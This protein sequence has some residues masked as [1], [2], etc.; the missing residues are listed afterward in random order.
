MGKREKQEDTIFPDKDSISSKNRL[1][2]VCDGMGG[3]AK[4]EVA[5]ATVCN[6]V[7][8]WINSHM[9]EDGTLTD[10][11]LR[12]AINKAR[13][14]LDKYDDGSLKKMGTTLTL[15]SIHNGGVTM[16][17]I[18]DSR[19]YHIRPKEHRILYKTIDHSLVYDM[20][21][22]GEISYEE[23]ATSARRNVITRALMP[24]EDNEVDIDITHTTDVLPG[25]YFFL[26]TDGMLEQTN[27]KQL[28]DILCAEG[29]DEKKESL[30]KSTTLDNK[31]NH[32]AILV[33]IKE[34]AAELND[35]NLLND[36]ATSPFN[37]VALLARMAQT[38]KNESIQM[39][40]FNSSSSSH[41]IN[42][43]DPHQVNVTLE[44][45]ETMHN[46]NVNPLHK[47]II[48]ILLALAAVGVLLY[49]FLSRGNDNKEEPPTRI[50][51]NVE[52]TPQEEIN[53][54]FAPDNTRET[55]RH[56]N[57][58]SS[59]SRTQTT[60]E[61]SAT[62]KPQTTKASK[63]TPAETKKDP[64]GKVVSALEEKEEQEKSASENAAKEDPKQNKKQIRIKPKTPQTDPQPQPK[65]EPETITI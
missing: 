29:S 39:D 58:A 59:S 48:P 50:E 12:E 8:Q 10:S 63:N 6:A 31:D 21:Q 18:G 51:S 38:A 44:Y 30:L 36:E 45:D 64:V 26:C 11:V 7:S 32:S 9:T 52:Q 41:S 4:G 2:L 15:L 42:H 16:G 43:D 27:D 55:G 5:S 57:N 40:S 14:E 54:Y 17:H 20:F 23:M 34:V 28:L 47:L 19:I 35:E 22:S 24:G 3:H 49:L 33:Q 53:D 46:R 61:K 1:F 60:N 62:S 56:N 65:T 13:A 37:E 25:D